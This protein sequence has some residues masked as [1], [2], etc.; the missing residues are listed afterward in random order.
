MLTKKLLPLEWH[1]EKLLVKDLK[2]WKE[3]PRTITKE[4]LKKLKNRI[5]NFIREEIE[6]KKIIKVARFL[7]IP[8]QIDLVKKY[9][10]E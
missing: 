1:T 2:T 7:G 6:I 4:R 10:K 3:N 9:D 5:S 8:I